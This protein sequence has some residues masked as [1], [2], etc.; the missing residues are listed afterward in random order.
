[1]YGVLIQRPKNT[2][3]NFQPVDILRSVVIHNTAINFAHALKKR[4]QTRQHPILLYHNIGI[5]WLFEFLQFSPVLQSVCISLEALSPFPASLPCLAARKTAPP[6]RGVG[7]VAVPPVAERPTQQKARP[8][9]GWSRFCTGRSIGEWIR[10]AHDTERSISGVRL[11]RTSWCTWL[12]SLWF[13]RES[14]WFELRWSW[15]SGKS[16]AIPGS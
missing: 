14:H 9:G 2:K 6:G 16:F 4:L 8:W 3:Q 12:H 7:A 10:I 11:V 1:M 15:D 13:V 5:Y